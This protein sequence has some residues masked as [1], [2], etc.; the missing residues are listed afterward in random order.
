MTPPLLSLRGLTIVRQQGAELLPLVEQLSFDVQRGECLGLTGGSGSGKSMTAFALMRLLAWPQLQ[1]QS[2]QILF[3]G[4]DLVQMDDAGLQALRGSQLSIVLQDAG[5][6]LHPL[7][8]VREQLDELCRYHTPPWDG[9]TSKERQLSTLREVGFEAPEAVLDLYPHQLSGGM[10]QR[11][12]LSLALYLEPKL[13]IADEPTSAL[14]ASLQTQI[15]QILKAYV[16]KGERS[17]IVISHDLSWLSDICNRILVLKEGRLID[18]VKTSELWSQTAFHPYTKD[19]IE[20]IPRIPDGVRLPSAREPLVQVE[21]LSYRAKSFRK[22]EKPFQLRNVSLILGLGE[23]RAL[24]GESGSGKSTLARI[25]AGLLKADAGQ[26]LWKGKALSQCT[27]Q[28]RARRVQLVLQDASL[29]LHPYR[30][31]AQQLLEVAR[32][33]RGLSSLKA[34]EELETWR[35]RLGLAGVSLDAF[36]HELSGGQRQRVNILRAL[37]CEPELLICDEPFSA[38]DRLNQ[39]NLL[40]NLVDWQTKQGATLL[41]IAHDLPLLAQWTDQM[42]VIDRGECVEQGSSLEIWHNPQHPHT[43]KLLRSLPGLYRSK[44]SSHS[45][46]LA[47]HDES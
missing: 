45:K 11:V 33:V 6:S 34:K 23:R 44:D 4:Q 13:I 38:L 8:T 29:A 30:T 47:P 40:E 21:A 10:R 25:L 12:L 28:Q 35:A 3:D 1:I 17:L 39:Q 32:V 41:L 16:E 46:A 20:A 18:E 42:T 43:R 2:G 7:K 37:L 36:P 14:D 27:P 9:Q 15:L 19:L 26:V 24:V 22:L 5:S 31:I